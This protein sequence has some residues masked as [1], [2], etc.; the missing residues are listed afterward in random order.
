[1]K[2]VHVANETIEDGAEM[3]VRMNRIREVLVTKQSEWHR[4]SKT[5]TKLPQNSHKTHTMPGPSNGSRS[6]P[7]VP[8][9]EKTCLATFEGRSPK[10]AMEKMRRMTNPESRHIH[11][12]MGMHEEER[13]CV[14]C[15]WRGFFRRFKVVRGFPIMKDI[16]AR[17]SK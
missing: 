11:D 7:L 8:C 10:Q 14:V 12:Q 1:M 3:W 5:R 13:S 15:W 17:E 4:P 9:G 2:G 6:P 16:A